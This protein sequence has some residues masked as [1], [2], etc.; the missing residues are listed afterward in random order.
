MVAGISNRG[1]PS[2]CASRE[3]GTRRREGFGRHNGV[4]QGGQV[5]KRVE[6]VE[7][8]GVPRPVTQGGGVAEKEA[9]AVPELGE[10]LRKGGIR[11]SLKQP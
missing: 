8:G 1:P 6:E 3:R 4:G 9:V 10:P 11:L 7:E 2:A 5:A